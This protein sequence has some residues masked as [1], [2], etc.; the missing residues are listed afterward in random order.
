[1]W[2]L[3]FR[4]WSALYNYFAQHGVHNTSRDHISTHSFHFQT[5]T[6]RMDLD[7]NNKL[8]FRHK[9]TNHY[10]HIVCWQN[11][12]RWRP[13]KICYHAKLKRSLLVLQ[14]D[15][16]IVKKKINSDWFMMVSNQLITS[17][18]SRQDKA[19]NL[20]KS[21][22]SKIVN[23]HNVILRKFVYQTSCKKA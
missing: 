8:N 9:R 7:T 16:K 10:Q 13:W 4:V 2:C 14:T 22:A 15:F 12:K 20:Q 11:S 19:D 23:L 3:M 1:M 5:S 6:H 17:V 21:F 18:L